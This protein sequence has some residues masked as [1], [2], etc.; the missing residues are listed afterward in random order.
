M[1]NEMTCTLQV[2]VPLLCV[3]TNDLRR[4][5]YK[6][7]GNGTF[8]GGVSTNRMG[9]ASHGLALKSQSRLG[10]DVELVSD[11]RKVARCIGKERV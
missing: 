6:S 10:I 8:R 1:L 5:G 3:P 11:R 2:N 7:A 9:K 4:A